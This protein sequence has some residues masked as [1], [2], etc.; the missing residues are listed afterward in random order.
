MTIKLS[1]KIGVKQGEGYFVEQDL[2]EVLGEDDFEQLPGEQKENVIEELHKRWSNPAS[3][4]VKRMSSFAEKS[5]DILK[6][7]LVI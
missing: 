7:I 2:K 6:P 4:I 3:E 5:P 1:V